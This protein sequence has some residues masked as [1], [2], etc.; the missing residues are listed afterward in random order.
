MTGADPS[1][2]YGAPMRAR[3]LLGTARFP[4]PAILADSIRASACEIVTVSLRREAGG[5]RAGESFTTTLRDLA[6]V[7]L[8]AALRE[9]L[10]TARSL[11]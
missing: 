11:R 8:P 5:S 6:A 1:T 10:M 7:P 9:Q 4:S 3:L 2:F